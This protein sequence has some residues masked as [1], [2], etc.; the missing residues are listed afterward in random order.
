[1]YLINCHID[2][3]ILNYPLNK[4]IPVGSLVLANNVCSDNFHDIV[5]LFLMKVNIS[6]FSL[7]EVD[8]TDDVASETAIKLRE[9]ADTY[10][11][12]E[13]VQFTFISCTK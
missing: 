7:F 9:I 4:Q 13:K 10:K 6:T 1:M 5:V 3:K 8:L 11:M 2:D 12:I